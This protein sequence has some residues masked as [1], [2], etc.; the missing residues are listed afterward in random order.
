MRHGE[1]DS[2]GVEREER[3]DLYLLRRQ[4][5]IEADEHDRLYDRISLRRR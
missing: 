1:G 2:Q 3:A 5:R 4:V